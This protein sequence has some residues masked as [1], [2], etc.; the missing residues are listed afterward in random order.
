MSPLAFPAVGDPEVEANVFANEFLMPKA[1]IR[2]DL[3]NLDLSAALRLKRVWGVSMAAII[4]RAY[5][6]NVITEAKYRRLFTQ[7]GAGG[8]RTREPEPLPFEQ[9]EAFNGLLDFHRD[10]FGFSADDMR[11][12]LLTDNLGEM[13]VPLPQM[14]L[15]E[16]G[17]FGDVN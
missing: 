6:M 7:L 14:R 15:T 2:S 9:P 8:M 11:K 16:S 1:E 3:Q 10:K 13:P 12:L 5:K 17:L 4:H